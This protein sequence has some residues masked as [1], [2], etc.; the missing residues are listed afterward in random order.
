MH[1]AN[2]VRSLALAALIRPG[3]S[4]RQAQRKVDSVEIGGV[5]VYNYQE[6]LSQ[7]GGVNASIASSA[8]FDWVVVFS[9]MAMDQQLL[10]FCGGGE[11]QNGCN[12][13]GHPD[14]GGVPFV[15]LSATEAKLQ[16]LL[17]AHPGEVDFVEPEMPHFLIPVLDS[18]PSQQSTP[19]HLNAVGVP[20]A[21]Y[22]GKGVHIFI[23]DSGIRTS[24]S[25]FGGRALPTIDTLSNGGRVRECNGNRNCAQDKNGHGTHVAGTAGGASLG[26]APD[27]LLY[28]M[29]VCC[30][31]GTNVNGGLDWV[32]E[33]GRRPAIVSMSLGSRGTSMADKRT[34][35]TV[36]AGGVT[37][38][39]AS[40][41]SN[42]N[43]C[44]FT[45]AFIPSVIAVGASN[46]RNTRAWFS[47]YG[48]CNDIFAPGESILSAWLDSDKGTRVLDGTSMAAPIVSG[49]IALILEE[50][51]SLSPAGIRAELERR[52]TKGA[53]KNLKSGDP[54]L[55]TNVLP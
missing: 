38:V 45:F 31:S 39:V 21:R 36:V 16:E 50:R 43:S 8:D 29:R 52:S 12:S 15:T 41:N 55:L 46:S 48:S 20:S 51:P 30:G 24:H 25:E 47:N 2:A 27:A 13:L 18:P 22:T 35:D 7:H 10:D 14:N 4:L 53:L 3:S 9:K 40:G 44:G 42:A 6:R 17:E 19:W 49:T 5:T 33:K 1:L 26:V 28:S 11:G 32:L 23:L 34:V 37:V 54:N